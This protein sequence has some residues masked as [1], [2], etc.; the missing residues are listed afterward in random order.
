[1]QKKLKVSKIADHAML[2]VFDIQRWL[3]GGWIVDEEE[4]L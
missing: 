4:I 2:G 3:I 1:M